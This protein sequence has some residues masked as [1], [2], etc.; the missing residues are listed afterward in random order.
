[1]YL[2]G[3]GILSGVLVVFGLAVVKIVVGIWQINTK[4]ANDEKEKD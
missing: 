1:L 3:I 4:G 2:C